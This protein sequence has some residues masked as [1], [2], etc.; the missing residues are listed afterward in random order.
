VHCA[1]GVRSFRPFDH[2]LTLQDMPLLHFAE[3]I[4]PKTKRTRLRSAE[5]RCF[6]ALTAMM[7]TNVAVV[8]R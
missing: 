3:A 4:D 5:S 6:C 8:K 7:Q 2:L 1:I